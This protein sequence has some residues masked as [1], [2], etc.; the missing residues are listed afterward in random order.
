M[1]TRFGLPSTTRGTSSATNFKLIEFPGH[2]KLHSLL[3]D[4][5]KT[6]KNIHGL[7][8]MI[9]ATLDQAKLIEAAHFLYKVLLVTERRPGGV[10]ILI[11][12][13][14]TD[15]FSA[16]QPAKIKEVLEKEIDAYR[17][18]QSANVSKVEGDSNAADDE[19]EIELGAHAGAFKFEQMDGN[20]DVIG[21]SALKQKVEKWDCWIDE[22]AVNF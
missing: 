1:H 5:I 8:F 4:E 18:L 7:V 2:N 10:D 20:L 21:G 3:L 11:A 15:L 13:N 6:S 12:C 19:D 17:K 22:R 9:D 14:K 16:R